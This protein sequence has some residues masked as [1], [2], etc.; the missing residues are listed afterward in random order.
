MQVIVQI[1]DAQNQEVT[2]RVRATSRRIASKVA[3]VLHD[4]LLRLKSS[5]LSMCVLVPSRAGT[6]R[7]ASTPL[8]SALACRKLAMHHRDP[9]KTPHSACCVN[10]SAFRIARLARLE[11]GIADIYSISSSALSCIARG[12]ER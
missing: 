6:R 8:S 3:E 10:L 11:L 7:C 5:A 4:T 9:E 1:W 2:R 12:T